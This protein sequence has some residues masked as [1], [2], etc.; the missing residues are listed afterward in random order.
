[1]SDDPIITKLREVLKDASTE[2][3]DWEAVDADTTIESLGFDS[4]SILDLL[5]DVEEQLGVHLEASDVVDARTVGD[6]AHLL[7]ERGA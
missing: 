2:E 7:R 5:Y 1:M 4:L 3:R 6:I